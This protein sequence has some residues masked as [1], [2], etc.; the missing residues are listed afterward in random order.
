MDKWQSD[1]AHPAITNNVRGETK[2]QF[3][4]IIKPIGK[5]CNLNCSY[6]YFQGKECNES[7]MKNNVLESLINTTCN[8][9]DSVEFIWHGG[10]PLLAGVDFYQK[11]IEY[12]F[13]QIKN[14]KNIFNSIQTNGTLVDSR[15]IAFFVKNNFSVGI[16]LDGP[17]KFHDNVRQY[18]D[19]NG[20]CNRIIK[21]IHTLRKAGIIADIICCVSSI[22]YDFPEDIFDFF[23]E[24][25]IKRFKFLQV[26]GRDK[27]GRLLPYA[28]SAKQ[29]ANFLIRIFE[30]WIKLDDPSIEIREIKSIID[31]MLGG[32][33]RECMFAGECYKYFTI[34][35]DGSVYGCDSLPKIEELCFGHISDGINKILNSPNFIKFLQR[36]KELREKCINC[37]WFYVCRGGCLQDW[38]PNIFHSQT[39]NFFC[40]GLKKIFKS[41]QE[42]LQKYN[43]I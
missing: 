34:Y 25:G 29:Y 6:C 11:V 31:L 13:V 9:Q 12:E 30:K 35:S 16:S 22:N 26:Q 15:W 40:N 37:E 4:P 8:N 39:K 41:F 20:S 43:M 24:Q 23:I 17:A 1:Y 32:N 7:L 21:S 19:R 27:R 10:E 5:K 33:D 14:G 18:H 2:M 3:I 36:T 38:W 28:I 42:I